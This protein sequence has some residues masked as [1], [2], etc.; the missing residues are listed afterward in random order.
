[1]HEMSL[2]KDLMG[3]I[4]SVV[5]DN[6]AKR[7]VRVDVWL[8]ALSHIS[9]EHFTE[10]YVEA[11]KGTVGEGRGPGSRSRAPTT[12]TTPTPRTSC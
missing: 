8:G 1:M 12:S 9:P 6:G 11:A 4:I 10:H 7:A 5:H 3:K 2:M